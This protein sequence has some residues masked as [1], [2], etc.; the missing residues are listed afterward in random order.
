[1]DASQNQAPFLKRGRFKEPI[2][3]GKK[4]GMSGRINPQKGESQSQVNQ[5]KQP[6]GRTK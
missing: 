2:K 3:T 1:M 5:T 6:N 4:R